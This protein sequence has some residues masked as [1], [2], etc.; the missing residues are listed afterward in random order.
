MIEIISSIYIFKIQEQ[1]QTLFLF[2]ATTHNCRAFKRRANDLRQ[3]RLGCDS[4]TAQD[5]L[6][7]VECDVFDL[8]G[9]YGFKS[10]K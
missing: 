2:E 7:V 1:P 3:V 5:A 4:M 6:E 10:I 9:E 8:A